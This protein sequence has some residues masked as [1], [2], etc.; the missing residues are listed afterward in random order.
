[1][2]DL[3]ALPH[4]FRDGLGGALALVADRFD[5]ATLEPL[6]GRFAIVE[7]WS[8]DGDAYFSSRWPLA[9][10]A[11][12]AT[13][14]A[15]ATLTGHAAFEG[16][17]C[18]VRDSDEATTPRIAADALLCRLDDD[19][20][21]EDWYTL[22]F[23][24]AHATARGGAM[25]H[26]VALGEASASAGWAAEL[27][28]W[29]LDRGALTPKEI[30]SLVERWAPA[31]EHVARVRSAGL[32][33]MFTGRETRT[34]LLAESWPGFAVVVDGTSEPRVGEDLAELFATRPWDEAVREARSRAERYRGLGVVALRPGGRG[35]VVRAGTV[36]AWLADDAHVEADVEGE[37][38][39][40]AG[41]WALHVGE[42]T[43][44]RPSME[45]AT[46]AAWARP[47]PPEAFAVVREPNAPVPFVPKLASARTRAEA[48][49][50]V[51]APL[52][53]DAHGVD[54]R[55]S[56][57]DD[58]SLPIDGAGERDVM[59]EINVVRDDVEDASD[60]EAVASELRR[61]LRERPDLEPH[62]VTSTYIK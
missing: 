43:P 52:L 44:R 1:M 8:F 39:S 10:D 19:A 60:E 4:G 49:G 45:G 62:V 53:V 9:C 59:V 50:V 56:F 24:R 37:R 13:L 35:V 31:A 17:F 54:L 48:I 46:L 32:A 25:S 38:T 5:D 28:R 61:R 41:T 27:L 21:W 30:A 42:M 15:R 20:S 51:A 23:L 58:P 29:A 18:L 6:R 57:A 7:D 11:A 22:A 36:R 3:S 26:V 16:A 40:D 34:D 55:V 33:D 14:A 47:A 2:N 12:L